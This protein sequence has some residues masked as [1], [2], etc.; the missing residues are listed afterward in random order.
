MQRVHVILLVVFLGIAASAATG[1]LWIN[2]APGFDIFLD[3]EFMGV[4]EPSENGKRLPGLSSGE[5]TIR[6]EKDGFALLEFSIPVG[7]ASNQVVVGELGPESD[8]GLPAATEGEEVEQLV[9]TIEVTSD[10]RNCTV[11]FAGRKTPKEQPILTIPGIAVGEHNI[12]FES[13]G[14]VLKTTVV[15]QAA[16]LAQVRVDFRN[17]RIAVTGDT[18][19]A[20]GGESA[21]KEDSPRAE[22][23]CIEYWVQVMRTSNF[24]EIEPARST[25]KD[26][27]YPRYHQKLITIEDESA[28][29][30]YKLRVGPI[31]RRKMAQWVAGLIKNA[32][33]PAVWVLPKEC[34]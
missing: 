22:P 4:S 29:P 11:E 13:E 2:C 31:P 16:Q 25:L 8:G 27:G 18:S 7:P 33:F 32:G 9:G 1:D 21:S 24:D 28:P 15:V 5:H 26:L 14:T 23:E 19:N 6:I 10:P 17:Q 30:I 20:S 34:Q 3:G 12:R